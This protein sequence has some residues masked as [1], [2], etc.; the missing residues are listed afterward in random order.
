MAVAQAAATTGAGFRRQ[1]ATDEVRSMG[2]ALVS[3]GTA[4]L[5][6][7]LVITNALTHS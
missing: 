4:A 7:D 2:F 6:Q 5:A 3:W 1:E